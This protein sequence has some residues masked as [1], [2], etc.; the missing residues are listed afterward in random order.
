MDEPASSTTQP[1]RLVVSIAVSLMK[2]P[3]IF[4]DSKLPLVTM[5][6]A[7]IRGPRRK[8]LTTTANGAMPSTRTMALRKLRVISVPPTKVDEIG[9]RIHLRGSMAIGHANCKEFRGALVERHRIG[10]DRNR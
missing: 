10:D 6:G 3:P 2:P 8:R 1:V 9:T 7:A 5:F 4:G